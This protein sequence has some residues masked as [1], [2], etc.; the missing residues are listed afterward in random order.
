MKD[1]GTTTSEKMASKEGANRYHGRVSI[2]FGSA[3]PITPTHRKL[4]PVR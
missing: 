1:I 4:I 3:I 2:S